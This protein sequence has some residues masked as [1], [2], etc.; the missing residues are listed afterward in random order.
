MINEAGGLPF[1]NIANM[2]D[3]GSAPPVRESSRSPE[4]PGRLA[5]AA[6]VNLIKSVYGMYVWAVPGIEVPNSAGL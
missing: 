1:R 4:K 5:P 2:P 6:A 3:G